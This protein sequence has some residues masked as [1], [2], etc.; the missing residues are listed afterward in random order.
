M[1]NIKVVFLHS[2]LQY[3]KP[4]RL[5]KKAVAE[6]TDV[7]NDKYYKKTW[8][9]KR[10]QN[11]E[12]KTEDIYKFKEYFAIFENNKRK[13]EY[14]NIHHYNTTELVRTWIDECI[15]LQEAKL[16]FADIEDK[17]CYCT[18]NEIEKLTQHKGNRYYG[19]WNGYQVFEIGNTTQAGFNDYAS[20]LSRI[21][22]RDEGAKN[23]ICT[24]PNI[25]R[26]RYYVNH[27]VDSVCPLF[28]LFNMNDTNSPYQIHFET[29]QFMDKND[30]SFLEGDYHATR[31]FPISP[32]A[33]KDN[34]VDLVNFISEHNP[35]YSIDNY[36][37]P[38]NSY[39]LD[40]R[41]C[42]PLDENAKWVGYDKY[43][44][45]YTANKGTITAL[46]VKIGM[47]Y[48]RYNKVA[49]AIVNDKG[50]PIS[51]R[52][53]NDV[54]NTIVTEFKF[55]KDDLP[56]I[57]YLNN[58]GFNQYI[59]KQYEYDFY[60]RLVNELER[61][62]NGYLLR[63]YDENNFMHLEAVVNSANVLSVGTDIKEKVYRYP[64]GKKKKVERYRNEKLDGMTD[65]YDEKGK[66]VKQERYNYGE[67][68]WDSA[69]THK[70]IKAKIDINAE[71][72]TQL[73]SN[74]ASSIVETI[75]KINKTQPDVLV[76]RMTKIEELQ[77]QIAEYREMIR[78]IEDE[79][80]DLDNADIERTDK[81]MNV[82]KHKLDEIV[83]QNEK[84]MAEY[85]MPLI[86]EIMSKYPNFQRFKTD[87]ERNNH[88][89]RSDYYFP[90]FY[91][92]KKGYRLDFKLHKNYYNLYSSDTDT[93]M[94][95][96]TNKK[97][98]IFD[99]DMKNKNHSDIAKRNF[100]WGADSKLYSAINI[101]DIKDSSTEMLELIKKK[102]EF[103][104]NYIHD[105]KR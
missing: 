34:F 26:F 75:A 77:K 17:D 58:Y 90:Y 85:L 96:R 102:V 91:S 48:E 24:F 98:F 10:V 19:L 104:A 101:T 46:K 95:D 53:T 51:F 21:K 44:F 97:C 43:P 36:F 3:M 83:V 92:H 89:Y 28:V 56:N 15:K 99:I 33:T 23:H 41:I 74:I 38:T 18:P 49:Y 88:P 93:E 60:D 69:Y 55:A 39:T 4:I 79:I 27:E 84:T 81:E 7:C 65:Y 25:D 29:K 73:K 66:I 72:Y 54:G 86:D 68:V 12:V 80:N 64:N 71:T 1:D 8:L 67:I 14:P 11:R 9:S 62:K 32:S 61:T 78:G 22:G 2:K 42:M 6:I 50:L 13:F 63:S 52:I 57:R 59:E 5:T 70:P 47:R 20:I 31:M 16:N 35:T 82:I 30:R 37:E 45:T 103:Y 76:Q 94:I 105:R 87:K 40:N 100:S